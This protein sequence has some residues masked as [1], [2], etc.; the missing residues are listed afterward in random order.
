MAD[1]LLNFDKKMRQNKRKVTL[2]LDNAT[3][4]SYLKSENVEFMCV[5]FSVNLTSKC[6]P[7]GQEIIQQFKK[8]YY[9]DL[10]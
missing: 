3:R 6:Q 5:I 7:F 4:H 2:C 8:L 9:K 10:L 1:W